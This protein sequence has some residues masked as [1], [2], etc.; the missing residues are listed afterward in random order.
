M[1]YIR[2]VEHLSSLIS[3]LSF[4]FSWAADSHHLILV[5]LPLDE[6][7]GPAAGM[8]RTASL[9]WLL[10]EVRQELPEASYNKQMGFFKKGEFAD[11]SRVTLVFLVP[12]LARLPLTWTMRFGFRAC[13]GFTW[14]S[15]FLCHPSSL[16]RATPAPSWGPGQ[17]QNLLG[18]AASKGHSAS[19]GEFGA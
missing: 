8:A 11:D 1:F 4:S 19:S 9:R 3:G 5:H 15:V 16:Q 10:D 13:V 6:G 14:T 18:N 2:T 12:S 7:I 17:A